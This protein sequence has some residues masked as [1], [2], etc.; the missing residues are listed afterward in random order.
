MHEI[1]SFFNENT[2]LNAG[3]DLCLFEE[4]MTFLLFLKMFECM[5]FFILLDDD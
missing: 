1:L 2:C 5:S 4:C 3:Y